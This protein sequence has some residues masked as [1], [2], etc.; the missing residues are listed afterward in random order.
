MTNQLTLRSGGWKPSHGGVWCSKVGRENPGE[1]V[2]ILHLQCEQVS[3][4]R[5]QRSRLLRLR[6]DENFHGTACLKTGE[7]KK[8]RGVTIK[9]ACRSGIITRAQNQST[10]MWVAVRNPS[11]SYNQQSLNNNVERFDYG[12]TKAAVLTYSQGVSRYHIYLNFQVKW[13]VW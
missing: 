8:V 13:R 3:R 6:A 2:E 11:A 1:S 9:R 7:G 4:G 5:D 10:R 12:A